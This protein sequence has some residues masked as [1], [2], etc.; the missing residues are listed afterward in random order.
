[1]NLPNNIV[2]LLDNTINKNE[3]KNEEFITQTALKNKVMSNKFA[4]V[5]GMIIAIAYLISYIYGV[6]LS[7]FCSKNIINLL[8]SLLAALVLPHLHLLYRL[9]RP[10]K[11]RVW[12]SKG[13][14]V[15]NTLLLIIVIPLVFMAM[16]PKVKLVLAGMVSFNTAPGLGLM[17]L[18]F[19]HVLFGSVM[20]MGIIGMILSLF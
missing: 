10:C 4:L 14:S 6:Y 18:N 9:A 16:P 19:I 1:M 3:N 17:T 11:Q 7:F 8:S 12:L 2:T 15:I 5:I 20:I 13:M